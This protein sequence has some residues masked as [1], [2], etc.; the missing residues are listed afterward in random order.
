MAFIH[1]HVLD[2]DLDSGKIARE[3]GLSASQLNRL[4][5][6]DRG[7]TVHKAHSRHRLEQAYHLL[8]RT[9][10]SIKEVAMKLGFRHQAHFAIW[11]NQETG[12]SPTDFRKNPVSYRYFRDARKAPPAHSR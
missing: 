4:F 9:Q 3:V 11:F 12:T 5:M 6:R 7:E 2:G 8:M 1:E 10:L